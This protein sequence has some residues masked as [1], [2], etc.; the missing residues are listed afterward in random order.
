MNSPRPGIS[1]AA[2]Q[3]RC[4]VRASVASTAALSLGPGQVEEPEG[5]VV[6][7]QPLVVVDPGPV[8]EAAHVDAAVQRLVDDT[9]AAAQ[10][11]GPLPIVVRADAVLGHQERG[12]RQLV[13]QP[14]QHQ[15]QTL[16]GDGVPER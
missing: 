2:S 8:E 14:V 12:L 10:V 9:Q 16:C 5:N 6:A 15:V 1:R 11:V 3:F 4:C 7:E 13:L